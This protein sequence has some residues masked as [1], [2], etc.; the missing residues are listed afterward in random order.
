M[1]DKITEKEIS[2]FN[3]VLIVVALMAII[4]ISIK[5]SADNTQTIANNSHNPQIHYVKLAT[6]LR[7]GDTINNLKAD[8]SQ[9]DTSINQVNNDLKLFKLSVANNVK[10]NS[11]SSNIVSKLTSTT[12][13]QQQML[14]SE[15]KQLTDLVNLDA[16][17]INDLHS[18]YNLISTKLNNINSS[19]VNK[20]T[21]VSYQMIDLESLESKFAIQLNLVKVINDQQVCE[22]LLNQLLERMRLAVNQATVQGVSA[23]NLGA[24]LTTLH[25]DIVLASNLSN[26]NLVAIIN[27]GLNGDLTNNKYQIVIGATNRDLLAAVNA[28]NTIITNLSF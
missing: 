20:H 25:G 28:A 3:V 4:Y 24:D 21:A 23:T 18:S 26:P 17:Q 10:L 7:G 6:T 2:F 22:T 14:M 15:N 27:H 13:Q 9:I 5:L 12:N 19:L 11:N 8:I 16:A 1:L